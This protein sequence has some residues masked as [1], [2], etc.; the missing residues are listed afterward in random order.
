MK[1]TILGVQ[2]DNLKELDILEKIGQFLDTNKQHY[3][4]TPNPEFLVATQKDEKFKKILNNADIAIPDGFGLKIA[5]QILFRQ[6]L[7]RHTGVDLMVKSCKLA[8]K[9]NKSIYLFGAGKGVAQETAQKLK[10]QFPKLKI[11]GA[12]SGGIIN[13]QLSIINPELNKD[14]NLAKIKQ[15]SPDI[16]FVA[17]GQIKQEKWIVKNLS[18]LPSVRLAIGIGGSFDYISKK[19]LRAPKFLRIL[20][21]EWLFRLILQPK[22][23]KRIWNAVVVFMWLILKEKLTK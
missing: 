15:A 18:K 5:S 10:K 13:Y 19:T 21:L 3:I 12:H 7:H 11:A 2:I 16:L 14:D 23:L 22:R 17:L 4:V 6:K 8:T 1:L 9:K 20:G